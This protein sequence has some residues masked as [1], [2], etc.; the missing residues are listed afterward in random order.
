MRLPHRLLLAACTSFL[1]GCS[2]STHELEQDVNFSANVDRAMVSIDGVR[3]GRTPIRVALDRRQNH[4]LVV[5][6]AGYQV[7]ETVLRPSL[8]GTKF[9]FAENIKVNLEV[10]NGAPS[11]V[12]EEDMPEFNRAKSLADAPFGVD[13]VTY[14]TLTGDLADAKQAAENLSKIADAAR[15]NV[16]SA[17]QNLAKALATTQ[18]KAEQA[19]ADADAKI[20]ASEE[21]LRA[22]VATAALDA[23]EA[24]KA[25][26]AVGARVAFLESLQRKTD[27]A[28]RETDDAKQAVADAR[29]AAEAA[30]R[31]AAASQ[32]ALAEATAAL[33]A[34]TEAKAKV[35]STGG[36][37]RIEAIAKASEI[38]RASAETQAREIEASSRAIAARVEELARQIAADKGA[39]PADAATRLAAA[40]GASEDA[41]KAL[42]EANEKA[43]TLERQLAE[44]RLAVEAKTRENRARTYAEYTARKGLLERALR[45]GELNNETYQAA[46]E[47]LDKEL[48][49]R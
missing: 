3:V 4:Q 12:P 29:L 22:A 5:G 41:D 19:S 15:R 18:A 28:P 45:S 8:Q 44:S 42:A 43:A 14:G 46:V 27:V 6:K 36:A 2:T 9:G 38:G 48:R 13:P 23:R 32:S 35:V 10:A 7:Y 49:G 24:E 34:A 25:R 31:K 17:E 47:A 21:A 16:A 33:R 40:K 37:A 1:A 26:A 30:D 20:T 11:D 39:D